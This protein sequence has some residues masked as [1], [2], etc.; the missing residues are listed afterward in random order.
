MSALYVDTSA[1]AKIITTEPESDAL[2][3]AL[4]GRRLVTSAI[5]STELLRVGLRL[6]RSQTEAATAVLTRVHLLAATPSRLRRAGLLEPVGL[7]S[8]DALHVVS[9]L[10]LADEVEDFVAY[11]HRLLEAA[12]H[13]GLPTSSPA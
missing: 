2:R 7:R 9:A 1:L 10:D 11:D 12:R 13:H 4:R 3:T 6:G 8:L 5:A